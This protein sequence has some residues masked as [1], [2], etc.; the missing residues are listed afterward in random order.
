MS[1]VRTLTGEARSYNRRG[2]VLQRYPLTSETLEQWR[3]PYRLN[4]I[5]GLAM[6]QDGRL[7]AVDDEIAVVYEIDFDDGE[8][9]KAF[10]LGRPT[11]KGDFEGIAFADGLVYLMT[12]SARIYVAAEGGDGQRVTF[13]VFK[14][15]LGEQCELEGLAQSAAHDKLYL[16]CKERRRKADI[17]GLAIFAWSIE[18]REWLP[19]ETIM[20]PEREILRELRS[21]RLSPSGLAVDP[22]TGNFII[23]A[24][25]QHSL[26]EVS[27]EGTLVSARKLVLPTRHRQA[28]GIELS[29]DGRLLIVDEGG[30][31]RARLAVYRQDEIKEIIDD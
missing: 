2:G 11:E 9:L 20:L 25:R 21:D 27:A 1:A 13:E 26:I 3:L 28:E 31:Y 5:S 30:I 4:E 10:A 22:D 14:T 7:F 17:D 12:S 29:A 24:A 8:L 6:A 19:D 18:D 15:E 16:L 23:I